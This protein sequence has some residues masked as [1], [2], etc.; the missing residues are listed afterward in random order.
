[1]WK[2]FVVRVPPRSHEESEYEFVESFLHLDGN[3]WLAINPNVVDLFNNL[4]SILLR[5]E[6]LDSFR[7]TKAEINKFLLLLIIQ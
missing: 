4:P 7:F 1:M 2:M 3:S 6:H 5:I